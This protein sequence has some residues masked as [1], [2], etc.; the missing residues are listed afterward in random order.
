MDTPSPLTSVKRKS[1]SGSCSTAYGCS[2]RF[3]KEDNVRFHSY[4]LKDAERLKRWLL[5]MKRESNN[6]SEQNREDDDSQL[7]N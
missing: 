5:A 1:T 2:R 3:R 4:P 6:E 7:I